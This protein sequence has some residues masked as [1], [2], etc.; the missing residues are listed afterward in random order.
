LSIESTYN[1]RVKVKGEIRVRVKLRVKVRD[2]V[3]IN[4]GLL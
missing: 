2:K 4:K 3:R 1:Y